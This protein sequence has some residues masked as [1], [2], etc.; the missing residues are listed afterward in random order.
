MPHLAGIFLTAA[1]LFFFLQLEQIVLCNLQMYTP[2]SILCVCP[3]SFFLF[4]CNVTRVESRTPV[5]DSH[6]VARR[7]CSS[8]SD[9]TALKNDLI[10]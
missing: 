7:L 2:Y 8:A 6:R 3:V 9:G 5:G 1:S 4:K 10:L